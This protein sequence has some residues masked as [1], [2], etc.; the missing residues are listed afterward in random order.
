MS[1]YVGGERWQLGADHA[2]QGPGF[3]ALDHGHVGAVAPPVDDDRPAASRAALL[4]DEHTL[5]G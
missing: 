2:G 5:P 3:L 1:R 4:T